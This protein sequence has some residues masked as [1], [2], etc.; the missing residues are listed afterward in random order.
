M[1]KTTTFRSAFPMNDKAVSVAGILIGIGMAL[2][3]F[4][5]PRSETIES[6]RFA[7]VGRVIDALPPSG[8]G[9]STAPALA[10][11]QAP[12][13]PPEAY[14]GGTKATGRVAEIYVKLGENVF[15]AA[16]QAPAHLRIDA[17]RWVDIE[18]PELLA[19]D[20]AS[21]RALL[22]QGDAEVEA[23]DVVEIRFAHQDN[24]RYFPVKDVTRVTEFVARKNEMLAR[25][26]K[27]RI[28][29]RNGHDA[30]APG[31]LTQARV[32]PPG[33]RSAERT[34]TASAGR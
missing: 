17:E 25:D 30:T 15:M 12:P 16:N 21:A 32:L 5:L 23:G 10:A 27:R 33:P 1:A 29:A 9:L 19:N 31:W 22:Q 6:G 14:L 28:L 34:T 7:S 11:P 8:A 3:L 18:F 4:L 24:P 2:P 26:Y 20:T 13:A